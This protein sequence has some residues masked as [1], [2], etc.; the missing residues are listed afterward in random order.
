[1][2]KDIRPWIEGIKERNDKK[3]VIP[4]IHLIYAMATPC[5]DSPDCLLYIEGTVKTW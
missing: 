1:M 5:K 2:E 3:G 4:A